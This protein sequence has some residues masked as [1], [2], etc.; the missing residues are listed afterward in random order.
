M[1]SPIAPTCSRLNGRSDDLQV[2]DRD[3]DVQARGTLHPIDPALP[4]L[5]DGIADP[6]QRQGGVEDSVGERLG[7]VRNPEQA[8]RLVAGEL[9]QHARCC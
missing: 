4:V 3:P 9:V 5:R 8:D 7:M 1:Q 6:A 2:T